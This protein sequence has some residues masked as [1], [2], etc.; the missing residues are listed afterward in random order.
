MLTPFFMARTIARTGPD[1]LMVTT[2]DEWVWSCLVPHLAGAPPLVLVRHMVLPLPYRVRWL[3]GRRARAIVAV[4]R[5]VRDSLL[6]DSAID[7]ALVRVIPNAV[8]FGIRTSVP[9]VEERASA[10]ATLGLP[11]AGRWIGF[12]GG[13]NRAKGVEDVMAATRRAQQVLG[14]VRL[15]ICG[16]SDERHDVPG[17]DELARSHGLAGRVHY[18]GFVD[19]VRSAIIAANV[20]AVATRSTLGEALGQSAIDAMACGTPVAAYGL[21]GIIEA[22]GEA[23]V[24]ACPDD[25]EDLGGALLRLLKDSELGARA[26]RHG[27][28]RA[29]AS[30]DPDRMVDQYEQLFSALVPSHGAGRRVM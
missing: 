2:I 24:L 26:A 21:D 28:E 5:S 30:F 15:L 20:L 11:R 9:T 3:A 14:D 19:D 12:L 4:S 17:C 6:I 23:A 27:L 1:L 8:R 22:V 16:R 25:V 10:R 29:R 18:L 13:I 7:P